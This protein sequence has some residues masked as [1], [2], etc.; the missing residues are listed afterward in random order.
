M[1]TQATGG[2]DMGKVRDALESLVNAIVQSTELAKQVEVMT[3]DVGQLR[4]D[5]DTTQARNVE[6]DRMLH[7]TREQRDR[8]ER[9]LS[10]AKNNLANQSMLRAKADEDASKLRTDLDDIWA[11]LKSAQRERDDN[12]YRQLETQ[13]ALDK[14]NA[15]LASIHQTMG[16]E[17]KPFEVPKPEPTP[18]PEVVAKVTE[19]WNEPEPIAPI[20]QPTTQEPYKVYKGEPGY[21]D[22]YGNKWDVDKQSWWHWSDADFTI[23]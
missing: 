12:A 21:I 8:A 17:F 7:D 15:R 16:I 23:F 5:I 11:Q 3:R 9:E 6:L 10:E 20:P 13:E 22:R 18:E 1:D 4:Q 2:V 19:P 14:A